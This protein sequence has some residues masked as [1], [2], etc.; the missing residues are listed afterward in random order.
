MTPFCMI[1]YS[2][3]KSHLSKLLL[4]YPQMKKKTETPEQWSCTVATQVNVI[5]A[6]LRRLLDSKKFEQCVQS[7]T[8]AEVEE[9]KGLLDCV[10]SVPAVAP[11]K[12]VAPNKFSTPSPAR[13]SKVAKSPSATLPMEKAFF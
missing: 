5:L 12:Q 6:H 7:M 3:L 4:L 2:D 8:N 10:E 11:T 1:K 9:L 13:A